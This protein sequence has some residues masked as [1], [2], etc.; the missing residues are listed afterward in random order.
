MSRKLLLAALVGATLFTSG[1]AG[2]Q[3]ASR[4]AA[5]SGVP[6]SLQR[7]AEQGRRAYEQIIKAYGIYDDQAIQDYVAEVGQRVARQS[8][9]PDAEFKFVVLDD[10]SINAFTTGCCYVY[11][12]RGLLAYL[13]SEA[14]LASVLGHEIA[15]VTARH[16]SKR[17]RRGV[18]ASVLATAAAVMTGSGA[19]AD[20]ANIGAGA[21]LQG[22][23]REN[24]LE[25]DRLGLMF[26][27]KA[28]YRPEAMGEVF[29]MFRRGE[30]FELD[31]ARAEGRQPRIYHGLFASHPTPDARAVQAAKGAA[32]INGEPPGGWI[33]N[34]EGYMQRLNGLV[35]GSSRAQGILRENRFY[36]A[37]LGITLAFPRAWTVDNQRDSLWSYTA[38]RDTVMRITIATPK[39]GQTP[40]EFLLTMLRGSTILGG[41]AL[42]SNGMDGYTV[43]TPNGSPIDGGNGPVRWITLFRG[44]QAYLFA[45]ASRSSRN[46]TPEADGLFLSVAQ[47]LRSLRPSEYPLAEPFRLRVKKATADTRLETYADSVPVSRYQKEEL[48][49]LN[50]LYPDRKLAA[51]DLYKV[52]E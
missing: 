51:G 39:P 31:R 29:E 52:V 23:G 25:A 6:K 27:T 5:A 8:D 30:R 20:L 45:G 11:I 15:H 36:H 32:N 40:R 46:A 3:S 7:E 12:N 22:Y 37:D 28:G 43:R 48:L 35:Y 42:N 21:W 1:W 44:G 38:N 26:S 2:A 49:L 13:N 41:E 18:A 4:S 47:T 50:G 16:P 33:E 19:V 14:E 9:L 34:R 17:Q 24:E 10:Q